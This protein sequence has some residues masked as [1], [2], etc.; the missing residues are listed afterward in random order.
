MKQTRKFYAS[1]T[2]T[3]KRLAP[4]K[5]FLYLFLILVKKTLYKVKFSLHRIKNFLHVFPLTIGKNKKNAV[6]TA[7]P[8]LVEAAGIEPACGC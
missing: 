5:R 7:F 6:V 3:K 2:K 4:T 1:F 8:V